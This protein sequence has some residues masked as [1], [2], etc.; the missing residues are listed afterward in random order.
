VE[1][2]SEETK[3]EIIE[4]LKK[5]GVDKPC[6]RCGELAFGILDGYLAN[7][8]LSTPGESRL[9]GEILPWV[10]VVCETCGFTS[11]HALGPL[12]LLS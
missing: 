9:G 2:F 8:V 4:V 6:P 11:L 3:Q 5:R 1:P 10:A 12:E 7:P